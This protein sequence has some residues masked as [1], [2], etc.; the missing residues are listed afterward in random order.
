[1]NN[2]TASKI[3]LPIQHNAP[4]CFGCGR[5]NPAGLKLNFFK[6]SN[7]CVSTVVKVPEYWSGWDNVM[8]GGFHGVL[9]DEIS[10]WIPN[11][12]MK[13][14]HFVTKEMNINYHRPAYINQTLYVKGDLIENNARNL[15]VHGEIRNR[16]DLLLSEATCTII[17]L[18][19]DKMR[20]IL[21]RSKK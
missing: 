21:K 9:L 19:S 10:A 17:L 2:A 5:E 20:E 8:H 3:M 14:N 13:I 7:T 11:G 18:D 16:E 6:E 15:I 12:L 4:K 1:M